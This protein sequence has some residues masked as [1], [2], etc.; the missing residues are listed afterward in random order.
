MLSELVLLN[1]SRWGT[2]YIKKNANLH[3]QKL[4]N[5]SGFEMPVAIRIKQVALKG[6]YNELLC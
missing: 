4:R 6:K 3:S 2:V 1:I 5:A